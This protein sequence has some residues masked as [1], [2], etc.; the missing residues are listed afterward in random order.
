MESTASP[1]T[2]CTRLLAM[3]VSPDFTGC[4]ASGMRMRLID[5]CWGWD[6]SSLHYKISGVGRKGIGTKMLKCWLSSSGRSISGPMETAV[7]GPHNG[8]LARFVPALLR[9]CLVWGRVR[10]NKWWHLETFFFFFEICWQK[11]Y[12]FQNDSPAQWGPS[13]SHQKW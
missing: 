7:R 4:S 2:C 12:A 11:Q 1:A 10:I 9:V 3:G 6:Q 8:M 13:L 5:S